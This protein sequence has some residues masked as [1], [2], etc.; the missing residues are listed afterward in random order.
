V[1]TLQTNCY[2]VYD[3]KTKECYI[4]DP[5][6]EGEKI[7][8]FIREKKLKPI[9]I[10]NT[11]GHIDHIGANRKIKKEFN[12]PLM[13]HSKDGSFLTGKQNLFFS[14]FLNS[15]SS[16]PA[17]LF[18]EE[19]QKLRIGDCF[20]EVIHTPGHTP[21]S[22]S[23]KSNGFVIS[24]DTLFAGGVGRTDLPGGSWELLLKSIKTKLFSLPEDL[25]VLPGHGDLTTIKEE[26][27]KNP[28]VRDY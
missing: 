9:G 26:K 6:A 10:I 7:I 14:F 19:G 15:Q 16:P 22:I 24:G 21:G 17:D 27:E 5:G 2:I 3:N 4:I 1:G 18:I 28:F 25:I 8:S 12:I 20:L 11:H 13:I 23:L